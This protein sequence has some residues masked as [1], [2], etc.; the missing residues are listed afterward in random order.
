ML[1]EHYREKLINSI[2]YFITNTNNCGKTKLFK[3][4]FFLDFSHFQQTGKS[5][6]GID[7]Y[8][9]DF[10]PAPKELYEE[11]KNPKPDLT[12]HI[13]FQNAIDSSFFRI[14]AKKAFNSKYFSKR[15]IKILEELAF[16]FKDVSTEDIKEIS[17]MT[18]KPW[19]KTKKS[20]GMYAYIDY[21]LALEESNDSLGLEEIKEKIKDLETIKKI[22][23]D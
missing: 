13:S 14:R 15:E 4:L 21:F 17:H 12:T 10:G 19:D 6:T 18:D 20:K 2:I 22:F 23:N 7:Y 9:W 11:F 3:L 16:I 5:V 8:A 1:I